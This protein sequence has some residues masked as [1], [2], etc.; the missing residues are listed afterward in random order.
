LPISFDD[1]LNYLTWIDKIALYLTG[2]VPDYVGKISDPDIFKYITLY[3]L[4]RQKN[5]RLVSVWSP[6]FLLLLLRDIETIIPNIIKD[7]ET[8]SLTYSKQIE[9]SILQ[10]L[11]KTIKGQPNR[12]KELQNIWKKQ[13]LTL[14]EK[15]YLTWPQIKLISA[16][17]DAGAELSIKE[18]KKLFPHVEIQ[19]KGLIATEAFVSFPYFSKIDKPTGSVLSVRSHF[20]EFIP[21]DNNNKNPNQHETPLLAHELK[22]GLRY[23]L[24]I[25]TAGGLYRYQLQDIVEVTGYLRQIPILKF[26]GKIDHVVDMTGEKINAQH[27]SEILTLLSDKYGYKADFQ[28]LAPE[29]NKVSFLYTLYL[30]VNTPVNNFSSLSSSLDNA[31]ST[32]YHYR[33]CRSLGQLSKPRIFLINGKSC[34]PHIIYLQQHCKITRLGNIK[35]NFLDSRLDWT[36]HFEG[37]YI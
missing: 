2:T 16:W 35:P 17:T 31:L 21:H 10:K 11:K 23:R 25:T 32:N 6:T 34:C 37:N 9:T 13:D 3:Y 29:Q 27:V 19:S 20:F 36:E 14:A 22:I 28:L 4:V 33:Y 15:L 1:D 24:L 30:S 8:G 7:I 5:L 12:A 26:C 18:V